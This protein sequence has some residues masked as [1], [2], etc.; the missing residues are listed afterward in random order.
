VNASISGDGRSVVYSTTA[1]NMVPG[2]NNKLQDIFICHADGIG[3]QR[4]SVGAGNQ[5]ADGDSP[6]EQGG[7]I[8]IS[9]DGTWITYNSAASNL[10]VAKGN[11]ILQNTRTGKI[12]PVTNS[13]YN[14]T[15]R[16]MVSR[17][18]AYV[19]AGCSEK[20][21]TRYVSSGIFEFFTGGR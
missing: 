21:D 9:Y 12:I 10:G 7:K 1:T 16:P 11:I 18:G 20:L 14:T 15:G 3:V 8:G 17:T 6:V 19:V 5:E 2:D 4:L 13:I